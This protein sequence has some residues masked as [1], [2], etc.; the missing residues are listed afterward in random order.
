MKKTVYQVLTQVFGVVLIIVGIGAL[1]GGLFAQ[2]YVR[3]QL[4]QENIAM[5]AGDSL[6][7]LP[8]ADQKA[9][10]PY[11]GKT[12]ATGGAAQAY[13]NNYIWRHMKEACNNVKDAQGNAL[14]AVPE[15]QCNYAGIGSFA[16]QA[17]DPA[18]TTA[19]NA[20]R[21]SNFQGDA[22][23]SMLLTAYA[24]WLIGTIAIVAAIACLVLGVGLLVL[25]FTIFKNRGAADTYATEQPVAP[26]AANAV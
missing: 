12:M 9:L 18:A 20:L 21:A 8:D 2:S 23:R 11:E 24:F 3:G 5:P 6:T 4:A 26:P 10:K 16:R 25:S 14:P 1:I 7:A 22:L 19:Y 15:D 17:K 13:A